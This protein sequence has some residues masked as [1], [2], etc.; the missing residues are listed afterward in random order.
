MKMQPSEGCQWAPGPADCCFEVTALNVGR[1]EHPSIP[2]LLTQYKIVLNT[3]GMVRDK[4]ADVDMDRRPRKF[5]EPGKA[6]G[7]P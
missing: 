1:V 2:P 5:A 3:N 4:F 6:D 7:S